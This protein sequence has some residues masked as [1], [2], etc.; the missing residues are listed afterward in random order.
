MKKIINYLVCSASIFV[1]IALVLGG[2]VFTVLGLIV[3]AL[4][5]VWGNICPHMWRAFWVANMRIL[6]RF[7]CL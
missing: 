2:G 7:D 6:A 3:C 1:A 5:Y 4:L